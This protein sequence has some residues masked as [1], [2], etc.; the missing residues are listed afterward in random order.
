[1]TLYKAKV[2]LITVFESGNKGMSNPET[3]VLANNVTEAIEKL[4]DNYGGDL[5][6]IQ[7]VKV[8]HGYMDDVI[9]W[10]GE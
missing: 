3:C 8:I 4:K 1:M 10:V 5:E 9:G 2:T 6:E 7:E